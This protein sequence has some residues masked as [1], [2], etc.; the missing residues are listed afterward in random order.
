MLIYANPAIVQLP[1]GTPEGLT[2][3][4]PG[5]GQVDIAAGRALIRRASGVRQ[6]AIR[7]TTLRKN[8]FQPW[9]QGFNGNGLPSTV[10]LAANTIYHFYLIMDANGTVDAYFDTS[11]I[12]ANR[13]SG[14]DARMIGSILS[15]AS[16][17]VTDFDQQDNRFEYRNTIAAADTN[18]LTTANSNVVTLPTPS[19]ASALGTIITSIASGSATINL[20]AEADVTP[21]SWCT[22]MPGI[23]LQHYWQISGN[24]M[25]LYCSNGVIN[26]TVGIRIR[27]FIHPR[28]SQG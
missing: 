25:R 1:L 22:A 24:R 28:G 10:P 16:S 19:V 17:G 13:P 12:A 23:T 20:S 15:T 21:G 6:I 2:L 9:A 7:T 4:F 5:A 8:L 18:N 14:W 11:P 27:G 26:T 3:S